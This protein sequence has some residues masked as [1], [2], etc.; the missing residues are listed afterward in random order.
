TP[1]LAD[2][3][4]LDLAPHEEMFDT[5]LG[6]AVGKLGLVERSSRAHTAFLN[7]LR[8]D[9]FVKFMDAAEEL[10]KN[11]EQDLTLAKAYADFINNSTGRGSLDIGQWKLERNARV[12]N[13]IFFAPRNMS[14]QIR[15]WN[16]VLNPYE[17]YKAD[18]VLRK[19][20]LRSLFAV[21]GT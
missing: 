10:G 21:A 16:T 3:V 4:G 1:S 8:S 20:A 7:K 13:D 11:P 18:P 15:T 2:K 17:Y 12:L 14:G 9:M 6:K 5:K 19:Q